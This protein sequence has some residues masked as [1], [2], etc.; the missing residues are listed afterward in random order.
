M[1][2]TWAMYRTASNIA[3]IRIKRLVAHIGYCRQ[4]RVHGVVVAP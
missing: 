2:G 1:V 4:N 3:D